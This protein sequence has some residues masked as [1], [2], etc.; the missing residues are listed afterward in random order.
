[1]NFRLAGHND[2]HTHYQKGDRYSTLTLLQVYDI[3]YRDKSTCLL[4]QWLI[5]ENCI[6]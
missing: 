4:S 3:G 1:M 5:L 6:K 2:S